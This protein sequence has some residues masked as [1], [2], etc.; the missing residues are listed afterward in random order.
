MMQKETEYVT[1]IDN[2]KIK[3]NHWQQGALLFVDINMRI[4]IETP[5]MQDY[6]P[7]GLYI[8][9]TQDCDLLNSDLQK[10][11]VARP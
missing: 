5:S 11:P 3:A 6:L 1:A 9:L 8:V 10:E 4:S 7:E 2:Q